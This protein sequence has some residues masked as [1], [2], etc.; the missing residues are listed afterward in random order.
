LR[1]RIRREPT[2]MA[3][4]TYRMRN[5]AVTEIR[6]SQATIPLAWLRTKVLHRSPEVPRGVPDSR[7]LA[8]VRGET[9]MPSFNFNSFEIRSSPQLGLSRSICRISSRRFCGSGGRP[10]FVDFRRQII[11]KVIRCHFSSV[12]GFT[13]T[14]ASRQSN[15]L[16]SATIARRMDRVVRAL[17]ACRSSK[18]ASC[19]R[20]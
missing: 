15:S 1:C 13:I 14:N 20:R 9:R 11:L 3:T 2:S 18:R 10:S 16:E 17:L 7:Y 12:S 5:V 8:T 4:N 6:K 19:F